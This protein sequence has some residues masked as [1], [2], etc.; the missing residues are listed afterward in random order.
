VKNMPHQADG[1]NGQCHQDVVVAC[2]RVGDVAESEL[3]FSEM[4]SGGGVLRLETGQ[5][6]L[7]TNSRNRSASC[8]LWH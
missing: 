8:R 4:E 7:L 5:L 6:D 3:A 2:H 1:V